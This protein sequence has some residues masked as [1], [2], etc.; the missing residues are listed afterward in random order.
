MNKSQLLDYLH[1]CLAQG[2]RRFGGDGLQALASGL[3]FRT[4]AT[5]GV[6]AQLS[7]SDHFALDRQW[8]QAGLAE[9]VSQSM[10]QTQRTAPDLHDYVAR[11]ID[12]SLA[13]GGEPSGSDAEQAT[14]VRWLAD[15]ALAFE[16]A[17][18][19]SVGDMGVDQYIADIEAGKGLPESEEGGEPLAH[20]L[21][22]TIQE[23]LRFNP[24]VERDTGT[25]WLDDI[26]DDQPTLLSEWIKQGRASDGSTE[27]DHERLDRHIETL[28]QILDE[29][30]TKIEAL[31]ESLPQTRTTPTV[32]TRPN[33]S[34]PA[35]AAPA[36]IESARIVPAG[37]KFIDKRL[38]DGAWDIKTCNQARS[39][40]GL[41][42]RF[43][44]E[45]HSI[46]A[47]ADFKQ[48][49]L[50]QFDELLR[51][52]YRYYGQSP[53]LRDGTIA[54]LR[55]FSERQAQDKQG[56]DI[57]TRTRH[58]GH[59]GALIEHIKNS[60]DVDPKLNPSAFTGKKQGRPR[61]DRAVPDDEAMAAFFH[62]P[63]FTGC[64]S[65]E[66][67]HEAGPHIFHRA[68]YFGPML[69][70][71]QG[72]RREEFCGLAVE[73]IV[74]DRGDNPYIHVCWNEL[75]RLKN[76]QS[77]RNLALHPELI[78]LGFLDYVTRLKSLGITRVFP[79]L[80]NPATKS[81]LGD[82]FYKE[83]EPI[84]ERLNITPHQFRHFF[85]NELKQKRVTAGF[86]EDMMGHRGRSETTERYC[87]PVLIELQLE[88]LTKIELRTAHLECQPIRLM[89]WVEAKQQ[90][91]WSKSERAKRQKAPV[92]S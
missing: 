23:V 66:K 51:V 31:K 56:L 13:A 24:Y 64:R 73:D 52:V 83:L 91:I 61:D 87:D 45:E 29:L 57:V 30:P 81:S 63:V 77:T 85:N 79:D 25:A 76:Q 54:A 7:D 80:F 36:E 86:R 43:L 17:K 11:S 33:P 44:E 59:I 42:G 9:R 74:L 48:R 90:P 15:A 14:R 70:H 40:Y 69:A 78:R 60:E 6:D 58:M 10:Q 26:F 41:L 46:T 21:E 4:L 19:L 49:H 65:F 8:G 18:N 32:R 12:A 71:Y 82:R 39:T 75:R 35:D 5:R 67:L 3:A 92:K 1:H 37:D 84:R 38:R 89:P 2:R 55:E 50:T 27:F 20:W 88:D 68:A 53:K 72:M 16:A 62:A 47:F 22:R 34:P 28:Q